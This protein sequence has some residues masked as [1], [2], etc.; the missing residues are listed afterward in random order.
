LLYKAIRENAPPPVDPTQAL[1]VI[2]LIT[3]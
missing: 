1:D 3:Q 2:R